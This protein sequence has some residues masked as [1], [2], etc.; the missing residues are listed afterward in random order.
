MIAPHSPLPSTNLSPYES[1]LDLFDENVRAHP[2]A[3]S[4]I[5]DGSS[6]SYGE[7]SQRSMDLA[8][9]IAE[10]GVNKGDIVALCL[11]RSPRVIECMLAIMRVGGV[12]VSIDPSI[13][14]PDEN[15]CYLIVS[16]SSSSK[17][18]I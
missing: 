5:W 2:D 1:F 7:L 3:P 16:P 6:V 18:W 17:T 14:R 15:L 10:H 11:P 8:L 9:R 12:F 4:L 13:L